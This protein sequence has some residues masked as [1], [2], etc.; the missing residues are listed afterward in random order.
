TAEELNVNTLGGAV[1]ATALSVYYRCGVDFHCLLV[2][3]ASTAQQ[4]HTAPSARS[5]RRGLSQARLG[6]DVRVVASLE[7]DIPSRQGDVSGFSRLQFRASVNFQ[8]TRNPVGMSRD[9][10]VTLTDGTGNSAST[11]VGASS[12]ALFYPPGSVIPVPK[13]FLHTI[14]IPLSVFTGVDL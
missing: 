1:T 8:D 5:S 11:R 9:F 4:P 14:R 2:P 10:S 7:N 12:N 6:W 13:V 3:P